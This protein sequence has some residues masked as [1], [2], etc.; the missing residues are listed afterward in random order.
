LTRAARSFD[1]LRL[2][3]DDRSVFAFKTVRHHD[4]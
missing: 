1:R 4:V 3:Q 2:S